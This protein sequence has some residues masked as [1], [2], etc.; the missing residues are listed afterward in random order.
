M[1]VFITITIIIWNNTSDSCDR[2]SATTITTVINCS[3]CIN[4]GLNSNR[5]IS[6]NRNN[7][8]TEECTFSRQ[9]RISVKSTRIW[10]QSSDLLVSSSFLKSDT[11]C[12]LEL[13][14]RKNVCMIL[15]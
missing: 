8:G 12:S 5:N 4:C 6:N 9:E 14:S 13:L 15:S 1:A 3:S 11:V 10:V 2:S 7:S